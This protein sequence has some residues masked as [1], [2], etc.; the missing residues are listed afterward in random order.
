MWDE[1]WNVVVGW[2]TE[3]GEMI[4]EMLESGELGEVGLGMLKLGE[5][6][7]LSFAMVKWSWVN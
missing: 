5:L 6:G 3:L 1:L 7:E 2:V 4:F